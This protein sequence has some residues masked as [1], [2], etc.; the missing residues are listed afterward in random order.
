M[1]ETLIETN[2]YSNS[3]SKIESESNFTKEI[4]EENFLNS[5][6]IFYV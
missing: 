1:K 6:F 5:L 4:T 2:K 3:N